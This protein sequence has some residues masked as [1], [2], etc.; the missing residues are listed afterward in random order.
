MWPKG[1]KSVLGFVGFL[2]FTCMIGVI[3]IAPVARGNANTQFYCAMYRSNWGIHANY[4]SRGRLFLKSY[5]TNSIACGGIAASLDEQY[6]TGRRYI[7]LGKSSSSSPTV[8]FL[9]GSFSGP[10]DE[11]Q[12][13]DYNRIARIDHPNEAAVLRDFVEPYGSDLNVSETSPGLIRSPSGRW[14]GINIDQWLD[15][16]TI[17]ID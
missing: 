5:G 3:S 12:V 6:R 4:P 14:P 15:Q 11:I 9:C 1:K 7:V 8:F 13:C 10:S 17:L 2:A 16:A